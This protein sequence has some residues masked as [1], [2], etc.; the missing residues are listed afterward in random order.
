MRCRWRR[1][2]ASAV[3]APHS[4]PTNRL[5]KVKPIATST[6]WP[7]ISLPLAPGLRCQVPH[8]RQVLVIFGDNPERTRSKAA[9]AKICRSYS[10]PRARLVTS[11]R[12]FH[13]SRLGAP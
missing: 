4:P 5:L 9:L 11:L 7:Q 2:M 6:T 1:P 12:L 8:R 10:M 13:A 3:D